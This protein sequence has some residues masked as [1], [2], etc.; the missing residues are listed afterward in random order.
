MFY[1]GGYKKSRYALI[2]SIYEETNEL[3]NNNRGFTKNRPS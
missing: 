2:V 1:A 3:N